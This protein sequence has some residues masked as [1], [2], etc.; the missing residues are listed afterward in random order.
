MQSPMKRTMVP[1]ISSCIFRATGR[2][3]VSAEIVPLG[4][5]RCDSTITF[6]PSRASLAMVGSTR[7]M[8]VG[9]ATT[10]PSIGTLKST[11]IST[12]L[13]CT[14]TPSMLLTR[15]RS[16]P[17]AVS[18]SSVVGDASS[19]ITAV[20]WRRP[21]RSSGW[22]SPIR[23]RTRTRCGRT[24]RRPR[25]CPS[26]SKIELRGSWLKSVETSGFALTPSTPLSGPSAAAV[27]ALLISSLLVGR[28]AVKVRSIMLTFGTGT[29][30][31][32]PSSLPFSSGSTRPTA[33]AAPVEVGI[34]F[35]A[36]A[37]A[38]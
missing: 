34:R 33:L 13:P 29:L 18:A 14:S 19:F 31:E 12:R 38:R 27:I 7:V 5:P 28:A 3:E 16:R 15:E 17:P 6:A 11:R 10:P 26:R 20:P 25:A 4:R 30:I 9:S 37:R 23:C 8:R 21:C 35:T 24:C 2:N 32:A 22:R 1:G 36:V